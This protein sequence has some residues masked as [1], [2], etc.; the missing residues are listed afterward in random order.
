M[1]DRSTLRFRLDERD[2]GARTVLIVVGELDLATVGEVDARLAALRAQRRAVLLDLDSLAFIDSTGIRLVLQAVQ[3]AGRLEWDFT[4]TRGSA[5]VR[6]VFG[7]AAI[8]DRLPYA[9]DAARP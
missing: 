8:H 5:A 7:A 9:A 6:R 4:V 1:D 3:D 2:D